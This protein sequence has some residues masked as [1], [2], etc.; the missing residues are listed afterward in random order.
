MIVRES[1]FLHKCYMSSMCMEN[2]N[3]TF[4]FCLT[5]MLR[6]LK[7]SRSYFITNRNMI[8]SF[9]IF[10]NF[11]SL[12]TVGWFFCLVLVHDSYFRLITSFFIISTDVGPIVM[13]FLCHSTIHLESQFAWLPFRLCLLDCLSVTLLLDWNVSKG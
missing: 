12:I 8:S 2:S 9:Y 7:D 5:S 11:Y 3:K 4:Y 6:E 1:I 13:V 10:K